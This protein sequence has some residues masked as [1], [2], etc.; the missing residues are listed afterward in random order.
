MADL[1]L[2]QQFKKELIP[3][4]LKERL[5]DEENSE[6]IGNG[7]YGTITKIKYCGIPCAA[8][9]IHPIFLSELL[10]GI[11]EGNPESLMVERFCAEIKMLS[12]I[13][14]PNFV[15]FIGVH[16]RENSPFPILVMELMHTSLDQCLKRCEADKQKFTLA[17]KLSVYFA[18]RSKSS[19]LLTFSGTTHTSS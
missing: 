6:K 1:T 14:H 10:E 18:R 11:R 12:E 9:E 19:R 5:V 7:S 16:I 3:Y 2:L 4:I 8:K 15:R 13:R 17:M